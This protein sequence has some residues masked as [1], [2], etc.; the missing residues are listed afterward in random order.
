MNLR[1]KVSGSIV[2]LWLNAALLPVAGF[3]HIPLPPKEPTEIG[4]RVVN[5]SVPDFKLTD[6]DG[7]PF[8]FASARGKV[9]LVTFVFTTCPD[10]C[11]LFT[12][13]FAGIQRSLDEKKVTDY[14]LLTITTDP[15]RDR[16][17]VLKDYAG[18]F[19]ADL[20][21]W[22]FLTGTRAELSK[23]WKAFGVNVT[24]TDSGQVQHTS[25]TTLVDRQSK[26]RVDYY[27]DKWQEKE[28]LKDIQWLRSQ[29]PRNG[30]LE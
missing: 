27:G 1:S 15:E 9:I 2:A 21:R 13:N 7:K 11:P 26:R 8:Q 5:T 14:L 17:A 18:R 19:K 24:K 30:V 3:A 12:A 16:A 22:S 25:L 23:V 10:V 20:T 29:K 28:I 6:Q 4:R